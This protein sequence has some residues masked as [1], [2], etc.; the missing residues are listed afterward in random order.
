MAAELRRHPLSREKLASGRFDEFVRD[1]FFPRVEAYVRRH[2][3]HCALDEDVLETRWI[4]DPAVVLSMLRVHVLAES[5][6]KKA[7]AVPQGARAV[8]AKSGKL[9]RFLEYMRAKDDIHEAYLRGNFFLCKMLQELNG[10]LNL[11]PNDIFYCGWRTLAAWLESSQSMEAVRRE[12]AFHKYLRESMRAWARPTFISR[13]GTPGFRAE[14]EAPAMERRADGLRYLSGTGGSPG[15]ATGECKVCRD[16][17]EAAA[18]IRKGDILVTEMTSPAWTPLFAVLGGVVTEHGGRL[19]HAAVVAREC[20][21]PAVLG[22]DG[23]CRALASGT[24]VQVDGGAG[25]VA[26]LSQ[27]QD[28]KK[29]Q[30]KRKEEGNDEAAEGAAD[31]EDDEDLMDLSQSRDELIQ[32]RNA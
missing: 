16:L 29:E 10:R 19:S 28:A 17:D 21:L 13:G 11:P 4:D 12:M 24:L 20:G 27:R 31:D 9:A 5:P 3:Y 7:L 32:S 14:A 18:V 1:P 30:E 25:T 2:F 15:L 23:A 8:R 26:V 6:E 22:L